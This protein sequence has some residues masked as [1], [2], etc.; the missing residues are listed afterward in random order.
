MKYFIRMERQIMA[1]TVSIGTQDFEELIT[2]GC[3]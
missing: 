1:G 2:E 3:F